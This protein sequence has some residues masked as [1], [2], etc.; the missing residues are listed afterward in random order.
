MDSS[1]LL[2]TAP[3]PA[4]APRVRELAQSALGSDAAFANIYL[5]QEKYGTTIAFA[6]GYF[7][8][9]FSGNGRLSGY[10]FPC[11]VGG[12]I[13]I[14]LE[15][16]R[17]DAATRGNT[18][19]FCLLTAEQKNTLE[20]L[21]PGEFA[22][23]TDRGDADYLYTRDQLAELPGPPFH[24]KRNHI[25]Q[26]VR[27]HPDWQLAPL[28]EHNTR[29]ALSVA[30][31][32]LR[33]LPEASPALQHEARAIEKAL[34]H[35]ESLQL[36]GGVLY[37][38]GKAVAMSIGSFISPGVADIHYEKCLPDWK[39][40]YPLINREMAAHLQGCRLINREED[41]NQEGLRKAKLSYHPAI[42]LEKF[43]ATPL[44]PC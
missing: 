43:S 23:S 15:Q 38:A 27:Q 40:A 4:D 16:I 24:S 9:H 44:P 6:G 21:Y 14:A 8:R 10:A 34:Q 37:V 30:H 11:G 7:F 28:A 31:G 39:K 25:A 1:P 2:F 19:R 42:L 3:V 41:L 17:R 20:A 5:L 35:R 18:L 12:D 32:W 33:G 29:D 26:F 13:R 22:F 36:F